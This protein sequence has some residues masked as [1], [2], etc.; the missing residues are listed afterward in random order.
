MVV[1]WLSSSSFA[2]YQEIA[3]S[4]AC[5]FRGHKLIT[6]KKVHLGYISKINI[7]KTPTKS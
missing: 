1:V 5:D 3:R 7:E 2:S 4:D 6:Q